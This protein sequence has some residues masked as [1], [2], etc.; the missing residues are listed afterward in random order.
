MQM[1]PASETYKIEHSDE[2]AKWFVGVA[3]GFLCLFGIFGLTTAIKFVF[4]GL[5]N[6]VNF[7]EWARIR[8]A[9]VNGV[10]F[11]WIVCIDMAMFTYFVPRLTG[12]KL[13]SE[14][15]GK[16]C[17][18]L[19]ICGVI[20]GTLGLLNPTD[21]L[22]LWWMTKGKE[23]EDY[24]PISNLFLAVAWLTNCY[25]LFRTFANRRYRQ[26]YV[27]LWYT[28]GTCLWTAFAY[29]IGNWPA[30]AMDAQFGWHIAFRG[31][32][33]ANMN[34]F[35]G[36]SIVGL[37]ATPGALGI[38]YYFLPKSSNVPLYSH[39][40]SIIGFWAL[41]AIYIWNGAHHMIYGP[42]PYW[43]QTVATIFSFLL[44]IPV[45]AFLTN[46]F[47]TIH[48]EWSQLRFNVP[49]KFLVGG[50]VMYLIA[51]LQGP[52]EAL[53]PVSAIVHF[54]DFTIGHAHIALFGFV[55]LIS[56]GGLTYATPRMWKR[57]L[58]S[59]SIAEWSFWLSFLGITIYGIAMS[60]SGIVQGEMWQNPHIPFIETV[61][62]LTPFW[63][64]RAGGGALMVAGMFLIAYN[65]YKTATVKY[66][67]PDTASD[68]AALAQS[69]TGLKA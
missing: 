42:I 19:W 15:I 55:T 29:I 36:H 4:P 1:Q 43:L 64:A 61:R 13:Y 21:S 50:A 44:F 24:N 23:M 62:V 26:M 46:F 27:A 49:L 2:A 47:G 67:E 31:V 28:M 51:C 65:T 18:V 66:V 9:H 8:P 33:D 34:W 52:M 57:P 30:Q 37:V 41:G 53:R 5:F 10:I 6:G 35:Y 12:T 63:H 59:E 7:L 48:G 58:Y 54:T 38:A 60:I 3:L 45:G 11:G 14:N 56:Y 40:L 39:K 25:N 69:S 22:N 17:A 20:I 68:D 32:N 16:F